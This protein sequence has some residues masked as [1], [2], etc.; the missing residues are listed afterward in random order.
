VRIFLIRCLRFQSNTLTSP[1]A[2]REE[3]ALV[4]EGVR[5][6]LLFLS[7]RYWM[8]HKGAFL[9]ACLG[10]A[11]GI[12]VFVS[13]QI[14]NASV[15]NAFSA[16][17]D[18]VSG[19]ANL[20]IRGGAS[21]L[22]DAL[23]ARIVS[24]NDPRI[25]AA[26]PRVSRTLYSTSLGTSV[27]V[28]GIDFFSEIDFHDLQ[29]NAPGTQSTS[30]LG[31][32]REPLRFLLDPSAI[33][34]SQSLA[35]K[36]GLH[37]GSPVL[38]NV[39]ATRKTFRVASILDEAQSGRAFGGDYALLDIAEAQEA[40]GSVGRLSQI[41]LRVADGQVEPVARELRK[42]APT[43]ANVSPPAQRGA[44]IGAMLGAFRLNLTALSSIAAFVGAFL[45]YNALASAVVRRR[46]E[47]AI[48]RS[49][50]ASGTQISALF[51]IEAAF[52]GALGALVGF[53]LGVL[54]AKWT[55]GAVATTVSQLYIAVKARELFIPH[56]LLPF[57]LGA[58]TILSV[59]AAFPSAREASLSS[60]R[61]GLSTAHLHSLLERW[62][63]RLGWGGVAFL[64]LALFL[65]LPVISHISPL[66]G[67]GAAGATMGGFCLLVPLTLLK[68][69][70]A[71]RPIGERF[72]GIEGALA[73]DNTRRAL[74]RSS[75]VVSALL[76]SIALIVGMNWMVRSFRATVA[77]WIENTISADV[78][79]ATSDGFSG[80]HGPGLPPDVV[81][82][83]TKR[84]DVRAFDT[85][86]QADVEIGG[87][88]VLLLANELP[89]FKTGDR[90]MRWIETQN[91]AQAAKDDLAAGRA[92]I[93]SERLGNLL[94]LRAGQNLVIPTPSGKKS[95]PIAGVFYDYNPNA[96]FYISRPVYARLWHDPQLDGI[97]LYLNGTTGEQFKKELFAHFGPKYALTVLP[98]REIRHQVFDTFDQT[99]AVT[100]ALQLIALVV[101]GI[102][103]FD[104]LASLMLERTT[105]VASLRAMG[106]SRGQ[107]LKTALWE[108]AFLG[109]VAWILGSIAGLVLAAQMIWVI[110]RQFFGWTIFPHF[111]PIV[112]AQAFVLALGAALVAGVFPARQAA[113]RDLASALQR[114]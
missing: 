24:L 30:A 35:R 23:F 34:V 56:W 13:I 112:L 88:Q 57:S 17:I 36:N 29:T 76:V 45:I 33:A 101:S 59:L 63:P 66:L 106:A 18:A 113:R 12:A 22:P 47:A 21:G 1:R 94:G 93:I 107:I 25:S 60:P 46:G 15:M 104:T 73:A 4:G 64:A 79:V 41:D 38:F 20:Q 100:Y 114:E 91:G 54:L 105:E 37:L 108:F 82:W 5:F 26:T 27:L 70:R 48:L 99:F 81:E 49:V 84:A 103:V 67:F 31:D 69:A 53:L 80:T 40:F 10:V 58:G 14:A 75:L 96:V 43:D 85:L 39:G 72:G 7:L 102:G 86:R 78:F 19:T 3:A 90:V 11:L 9:L 8:R 62:A 2:Q 74:N 110:N 109:G 44:Q 16:S 98:N 71:L 111:E 92:V 83:A 95:F 65:S 61:A 68:L 52:I 51:V 77:D 55:L 6:L 42:M 87:Q 28:N 89:S 97:A 32:K 50:G